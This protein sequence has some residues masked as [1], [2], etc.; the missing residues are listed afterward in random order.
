M[1][2]SNDAEFINTAI[3]YDENKEK[4]D[5]NIKYEVPFKQ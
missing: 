1:I 4:Y 2:F 5:Q 3:F